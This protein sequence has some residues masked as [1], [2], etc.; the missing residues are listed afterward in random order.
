MLGCMNL[1]PK[2]SPDAV[3][4]VRVSGHRKFALCQVCALALSSDLQEACDGT[5]PKS[6]GEVKVELVNQEG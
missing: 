2:P 4:Q 1:H 3:L 6:T 5:D